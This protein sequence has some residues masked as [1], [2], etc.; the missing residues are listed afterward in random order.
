ME[1][2]ERIGIR[3]LNFS[4]RNNYVSNTEDL[5][6]LTDKGVY[7]YDYFDTFDKLEISNYLLKLNSTVD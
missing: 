5:D 2:K 1:T 6:L 7:P 3:T 4:K